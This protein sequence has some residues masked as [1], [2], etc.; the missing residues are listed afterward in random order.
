[1]DRAYLPRL[2]PHTRGG[3]SLAAHSD[4]YKASPDG[5]ARSPDR[6]RRRSCPLLRRRLD[7]AGRHL[8]RVTRGGNPRCGRARVLL[9]RVSRR[10]GLPR[11]LRHGA[12]SREHGVARARPSRRSRRAPR[13]VPRTNCRDSHPARLRHARAQPAFRGTKQIL[14]RRAPGHVRVHLRG[15]PHNRSGLPLARPA[16]RM[17]GQGDRLHQLVQGDWCDPRRRREP[18]PR[19]WGRRHRNRRLHGRPRRLR[20]TPVAGHNSRLPRPPLRPVGFL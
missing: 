5:C 10:V 15:P 6:R 4:R 13:R 18:A 20:H 9:D 19:T 12:D 14:R 11:G 2:Q 17:D 16:G 7:D 8:G 1:G 3:A